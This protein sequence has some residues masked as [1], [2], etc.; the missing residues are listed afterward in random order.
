MVCGQ[1]KVIS[2]A[3]KFV[4]CWELYVEV[5]SNPDSG[6]LQGAA[7]GR[8][9]DILAQIPLLTCRP[10]STLGEVMKLLVT[11]R[12]H[13]IYVV[14]EEGAKPVGVITHT[15]ILTLLTQPEVGADTEAGDR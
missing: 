4:H 15:D 3:L 2:W 9:K 7:E 1:T 8:W 5:L 10:N 6:W 14:S 11:S 12:V 13:R